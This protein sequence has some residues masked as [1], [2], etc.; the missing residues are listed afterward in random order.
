MV[1]VAF[2]F[3]AKGSIANKNKLTKT[4]TSQHRICTKT[5]QYHNHNMVD[6]YSLYEV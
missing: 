3:Y 5:S 6:L 2:K 1:A 4:K